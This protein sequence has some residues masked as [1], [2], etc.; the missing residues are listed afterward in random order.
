M[1]FV[2]RI[3]KKVVYRESGHCCFL[4]EKVTSLFHL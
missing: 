1:L 3:W 2:F 4:S